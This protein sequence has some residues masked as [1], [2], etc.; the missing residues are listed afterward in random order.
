M[1][2]LTA[3]VI[4]AGNR[5]GGYSHYMSQMPDKY[6]VVAVAD[7]NQADREYISKLH[8]IP[9]ENCYDGWEQILAL[10]KMSDIAVISTVDDMHYEPA[11][12]AISLGYNLLLE[13]PVAIH[14]K[15][16]AD[17]AR[18][19]KEKGVKVLV[20]HVLR[21][22]AFYGAVKKL[23][24]NGA[25]GDVVSLDLVE[26]IGN[27]HF[28]HSYV[29][30]NWHN[31]RNSAPMLLAKSSHDLD[32]AQWLI[33]KPCKRVSSF[34]SLTHFRPE[35]AP[36]GAPHSCVDGDC[37][38]RETCPY[39]CLSFYAGL[40]KTDGWQATVVSGIA[41][42][43]F[44]YTWDHVLQ[45]LRSKAYGNCVYHSDNDVLDHQVVQMEFAG[46]VTA[47]LTVN[48][49]NRGGRYIRIYGTK[50]ELYAFMSSKEITLYTFEDQKKT[51]IPQSEI[52]EHITGGHG[53]G[54]E[55]II[56]EMYDY[57]CDNYN[58]FRAADI[59]VSVR[60]HM[61]GFA[62][63]EA[64]HNSTVVTLDDYL[65]KYGLDDI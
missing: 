16:C 30:G 21:Y 60:N 54:D 1:K 49:F 26:G 35:N 27:T 51:V 59:Q 5:G 46:G 52:D 24:M 12:K 28:A 11:M 23:V 62:A 20:C 2:Q 63:E 47:S 38:V 39:D 61:I 55:G 37:P 8:N 41:P 32:I 19:A 4:G 58:G 31:L 3:I 36:E 65:R 57:F 56:R 53:G 6:R 14:A 18:A 43:R 64:R 15:E 45:G 10:P 50:G 7:P 13:K 17:I 29:R 42:A 25:I 48:A 9:Q 44:D 33:D 34:G 40:P 22:T